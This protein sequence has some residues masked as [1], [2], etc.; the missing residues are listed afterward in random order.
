MLGVDVGVLDDD[1]L[2]LDR[3]RFGLPAQQRIAERPTVQAD[4]DVS[5]AGHV[6]RRHAGYG[7]DFIHQFGRDLFGRLAKL[8]GQLKGRGHGHFA[9]IGLPRLLD[10]YRQIYAVASLYVRAESAGDLLFN[11][12]EHGKLRV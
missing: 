2:A 12:M 11:G 1:L 4:V 9:E 3:G 6:H 5:V 7:S 8:F 10:G